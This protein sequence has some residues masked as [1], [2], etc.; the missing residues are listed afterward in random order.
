MNE[1]FVLILAPSEDVHA[2]SVAYE[3]EQLGQARPVILDPRTFPHYWSLTLNFDAKLGQSFVLHAGDEVI[4]DSDVSGVWYRRVY[5]H[6]SKAESE[7][8]KHFCRS[9]S[10]TLFHGWTYDLGDRLINPRAAET[11]AQHKSVQL[12]A[13]A[14]VGLAVPKT[15][16]TNHAQSAVEF[17][18]VNQPTVFKS[19]TP[20]DAP[21]VLETRPVT[22][23]VLKMADRLEYAPVIFQER[24][25]KAF[26]VRATVVD[27]EVFS[28]AIHTSQPGAQLDWRLDL[29]ADIKPH[30]L[31]VDVAEKLLELVRY[32]GLR[33]G[34]I[35]L[36]FTDD[37]RYVL[38]EI[39]CAG[40]YLFTELEANQPV[41]AAL[42]RAL[43]SSS[44]R[45]N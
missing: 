35:D 10:R 2:I 44:R 12:R 38:F 33:Y 26:D 3:V 13:A 9:E 15:I 20:I 32:L 41:S 6:I 29:A 42:A 5:P 40:Q 11:V 30:T 23:D 8:V 7:L 34:A 37:E 4:C 24:V 45:G 36:A 25:K 27:D 18:R 17:H 28:V 19:F 16:M 21:V 39:N 1:I 31:P 14:Q 43:S 22:D